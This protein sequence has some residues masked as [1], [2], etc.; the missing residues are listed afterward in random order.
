MPTAGSSNRTRLEAGRPRFSGRLMQ[1][2][3]R[4]ASARACTPDA[5]ACDACSLAECPEGRSATVLDIGCADRDARRL[6]ALGLV[7][8]TNVHV[9]DA[10]SGVLLDVRGSRLALGAA[11]AAA[12]TVRPTSP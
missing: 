4:F 2:L 7:E 11:L 1:V 9:I 8:G 12:I 6:R 10:R 5:A 3:R